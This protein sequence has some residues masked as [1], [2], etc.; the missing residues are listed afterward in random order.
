MATAQDNIQQGEN[1]YNNVM[2]GYGAGY[3][4][5]KAQDNIQQGR[6]FDMMGMMWENMSKA[7]DNIQQG[8]RGNIILWWM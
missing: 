5:A 6:N 1:L 7:Q 3:D 4:M 2:Y 8:E